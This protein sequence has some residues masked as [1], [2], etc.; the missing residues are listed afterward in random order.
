V[1]R[2]CEWREDWFHDQILIIADRTVPAPVREMERSIGSLKRQLIRLRNRPHKPL[3]AH[4]RV[5]SRNTE[6]MGGPDKPGHDV[7]S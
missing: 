4:R 7:S 1:A 3:Y 2:A 6:I 5:K